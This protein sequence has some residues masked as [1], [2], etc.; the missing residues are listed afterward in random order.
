MRVNC[1]TRNSLDRYEWTFKGWK[2]FG[3]GLTLRKVSATVPASSQE[4]ALRIAKRLLGKQGWMIKHSVAPYRD[5]SACCEHWDF[6][7]HD[8]RQWY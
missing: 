8:V 5:L 2:G 1:K 7:E 6:T 4:D 3:G